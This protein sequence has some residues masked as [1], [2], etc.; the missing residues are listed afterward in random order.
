[1]KNIIKY[2]CLALSIVGLAACSDN[3]LDDLQ[4]TYD[5]IARYNYSVA[6]VQPTTNMGNGIKSLNVALSDASG[7]DATIS[8]GSTEWVLPLGTYT[9]AASISGSN[10]LTGTVGGK[11]ISGGSIDVNIIDTTYYF[12]GF[13]ELADGSQTV[14]NYRGPLTFVVGVDVAETSSYILTGNGK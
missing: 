2:I 4:G 3:D 12:N 9:A 14:I 6:A 10:Q 7:N 1:M 11:Q 8:F 13:L 5:N